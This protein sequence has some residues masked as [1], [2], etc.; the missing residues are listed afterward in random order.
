MRV[1]D[2]RVTYGTKLSDNIV[3]DS[4]GQLIAYNVV[5]ARTGEQ[6]YLGAEIGGDLDPEKKYIVERLPQHVFDPKFMASFENKPFVDLHPSTDVTVDNYK[7]LAKGIIRDVRKGTVEMRGLDKKYYDADGHNVLFADIVITDRELIGFIQGELE[8]PNSEDRE[9]DVSCGYD[10]MY[11]PIDN[12]RIMQVGIT[13]NHLARVPAGRAG[14]AKIRDHE[15]IERRK[16]TMDINDALKTLDANSYEGLIKKAIAAWKEAKTA[17]GTSMKQAVKIGGLIEKLESALTKSD[18]EQLKILKEARTIGQKIKSGDAE[19]DDANDRVIKKS[20]KG[21]TIES[22]D[23]EEFM[24]TKGG[25]FIKLVKADSFEEVKKMINEGKIKAKDYRVKFKDAVLIMENYPSRAEAKL[26]A[27]LLYKTLDIGKGS[28]S[29]EE[30][31]ESANKLIAEMAK[32]KNFKIKVAASKLNISLSMFNTPELMWIT[33]QAEKRS[34]KAKD[35]KVSYGGKTSA[36]EDKAGTLLETA[37]QKVDWGKW[38]T[39]KI[40]QTKQKISGDW[41]QWVKKIIAGNWAVFKI[42]DELQ[43]YYN[44]K[45]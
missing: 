10:A 31:Q 35:A 30:R 42:R 11:Y 13:G 43:K 25:K 40:M 32:T 45:K 21:F 44:I 27:Q 26:D 33:L 41:K 15:S 34:G 24:I 28:Y 18:E 29:Q 8:K 4:N 37:I 20:H 39:G 9:L 19:V 6:D 3:L 38:K 23:L 5:I 7:D 22:D 16:D 1:T 36:E 14:I 17:K 12:D 2:K